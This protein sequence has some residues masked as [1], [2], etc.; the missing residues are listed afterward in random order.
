VFGGAHGT[1]GLTA[2]A[3]GPGEMPG[4]DQGSLVQGALVLWGKVPASHKPTVPG[5]EAYVGYGC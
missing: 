4:P 1:P 5:L 2:R 3:A